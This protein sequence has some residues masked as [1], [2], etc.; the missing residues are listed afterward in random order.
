MDELHEVF[1]IKDAFHEYGCSDLCIASLA[2]LR[3]MG[4]P[5]KFHNDIGNQTIEN[6]IYFTVQNKSHYSVQEMMYLKQIETVSFLCELGYRDIADKNKSSDD[7]IVF[8]AVEPE[9]SLR[10]EI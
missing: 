4:Y 3:A 7:T 10:I 1:A 6:F 2:L 9:D 8:L 5:I